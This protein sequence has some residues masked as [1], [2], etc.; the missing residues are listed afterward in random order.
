MILQLNCR[1][2]DVQLAWEATDDPITIRLNIQV[3]SQNSG[4][5]E[6]KKDELRPRFYPHWLLYEVLTPGVV[7]TTRL[8]QV[9]GLGG[10]VRKGSYI[11]ASDGRNGRDG[12]YNCTFELERDIWPYRKDI[13]RLTPAEKMGVPDELNP[14]LDAVKKG[15]SESLRTRVWMYFALI[16]NLFP[17]QCSVATLPTRSRGN[18]FD[19]P[20]LI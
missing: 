12:R 10:F 15:E 6:E 13:E 11:Y 17:G 3:G 19:L 14:F 16:I 1:E 2:N 18:M 20:S 4:G 9:C 5:E 8:E 7:E